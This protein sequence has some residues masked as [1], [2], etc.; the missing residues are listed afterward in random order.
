MYIT[1][2]QF[3]KTWECDRKKYCRIFIY[4]CVARKYG[5]Y[6]TDLVLIL[7]PETRHM[8]RNTGITIKSLSQRDSVTLALCVRLSKK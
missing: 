4:E 7:L 8:P 1:T 6:N 3:G 5:H 2:L